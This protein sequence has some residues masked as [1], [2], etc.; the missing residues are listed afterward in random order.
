MPVPQFN[1]FFG[2][3]IFYWS[4]EGRPL[5]P[6]H[7]HVAKRP[8]EHSTKVWILEDKS[9]KVEYI[10]DDIDKKTL[11]RVLVMMEQYVNEYISEWENFFGE[12]A[13]YIK[14]H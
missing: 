9:L 8:R 1:C 2:L 12:R 13:T 4:K 6:I 11:S 10:S 5:E 7:F 14:D 3:R